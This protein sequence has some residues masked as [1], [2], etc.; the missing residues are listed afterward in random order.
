MEERERDGV[1]GRGG[2]REIMITCM[3]KL[4]QGTE[5]KEL[6]KKS[7]RD[8]QQNSSVVPGLLNHW[9]RAVVPPTLVCH[10]ANKARHNTTDGTHVPV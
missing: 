4:I 3:E 10:Q 1:D 5:N 7:A 2:E 6:T 8:K 9:A